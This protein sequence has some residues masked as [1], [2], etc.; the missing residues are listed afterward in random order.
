[1]SARQI[2][3]GL[4]L[5]A[6]VVAMVLLTIGLADSGLFRSERPEPTTMPGAQSPA[7]HAA[8]PATHRIDRRTQV[9]FPAALDTGVPA[10]TKLR[11]VPSQVSSGP[12]WAYDPRGWVK[13]YG[14]GAVLSDLNIPYNV[15]VTSSD[16]TIKN[17]LVTVGGANAIGIELRHSKNVT[18]EDSTISGLNNAS[19]RMMTGIKDIYGDSTGLRVLYDDISKFET[20]VRLETGLVEGNYIHEPGYIAG[21][22]TNGVMSN[23]GATGLLTINHNTILINRGQTD[24]IGLFE[25]NGVQQNRRIT[26]NLLAGGSYAIYGGQKRGGQP[27]SSIVITGNRISTIYYHHG[28]HYGCAA[29][30]NSRGRRNIWSDNTWD[31]TSV[32]SYSTCD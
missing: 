26:D 4:G 31:T 16:V 25:D 11:M 7:G 20:G 21:D 10:G 5:A 14:N 3:L 24:A 32:P 6:A 2:T 17:V 28:G 23:G 15:S 9:G 27:T 22:H 18:I 12:G 30:F 13:V 19:G 1:M 8:G 29:H